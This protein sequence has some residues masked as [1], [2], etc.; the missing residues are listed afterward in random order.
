MV[1]H[2]NFIGDEE[3]LNV[4]TMQF[5][6]KSPFFKPTDS[7][8]MRMLNKM[9]ENDLSWKK[10]LDPKQWFK[11]IHAI[12]LT[13]DGRH[14]ILQQ[15]PS[16]CVPTC[17]GMLVLDHERIPDY[18]AINNTNLANRDEAAQWIRKAGLTPY[19][20]DLHLTSN[21]VDV[22][23]KCLKKRGPGVLTIHESKVGRHV[24]VLDAI[25]KETNTAVIRDSFHGWSLTIKLDALLSRIGHDEYFLQMEEGSKFVKA[26]PIAPDRSTRCQWFGRAI[27]KGAE[28]AWKHKD[29]LAVMAV[30]TA[31]VGLG[32]GMAT[33]SAYSLWRYHNR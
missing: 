17:V 28:A 31:F 15:A 7:F 18:D 25:S 3:I 32:V 19:R 30:S 11:K 26:S 1:E 2:T 21:V 29:K 13:K 24:I 12:A 9:D 10:K 5:L 4:D 22:L 20:T 23:I 16:S 14:V 6:R 8:S 27:K 33:T